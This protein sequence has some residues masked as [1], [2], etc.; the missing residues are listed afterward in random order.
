MCLLVNELCAMIGE[1]TE[2]SSVPRAAPGATVPGT[3]ED[4]KTF[5]AN[6]ENNY[7]GITTQI[8]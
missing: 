4:V 8:K 3:I 1:D 5:R 2:Q 7:E 6:N